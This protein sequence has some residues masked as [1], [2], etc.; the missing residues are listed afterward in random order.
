MASLQQQRQSPTSA[1]PAEAAVSAHGQRMS[2]QI[3]GGTGGTVL[4]PAVIV[5]EAESHSSFENGQDSG[6]HTRSVV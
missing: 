4:D 5:E 2:S 6:H 3:L 1:E